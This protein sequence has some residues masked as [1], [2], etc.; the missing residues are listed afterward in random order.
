MYASACDS[1][2]F[3]PKIRVVAI[4]SQHSSP[5]GTTNQWRG[6]VAALT[7]YQDP[8][9]TPQASTMKGLMAFAGSPQC[10]HQHIFFQASTFRLA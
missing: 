5:I 2:G 7:I 3:I 10:F 1:W 6:R 9:L 8:R 4:N